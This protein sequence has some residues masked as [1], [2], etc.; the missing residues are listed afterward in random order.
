VP[1]IN[2]GFG[3]SAIADSTYCA[4]RIV[5]PYQ[6]RLIV[7][8]AGDNDVAEGHSAQQ[9]AGDFKAFVPRVRRDLPAVPVVYVSIKPSVARWSQWP[10]KRPQRHHPRL[11]GNPARGAFRGH[12][13]GHARRA[14][15]A[16]P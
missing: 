15:P 13:R 8:C 5:A 11:G 9:V 6:P 16:A 14:G 12:L 1:V 2:R 10:T 4:D 3:G 7:M